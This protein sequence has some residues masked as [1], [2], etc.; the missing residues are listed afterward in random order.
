MTQSAI[1]STESRPIELAGHGLTT[2]GN[3][4]ALF[5][6][7]WSHLRGS[8]PARQT[9]IKNDKTEKKNNYRDRCISLKKRL[10]K[11]LT[12][13][14]IYQKLIS[15]KFAKYYNKSREAFPGHLERLPRKYSPEWE[16]NFQQSLDEFSQLDL[17]PVSDLL[18][19]CGF[20][21]ERWE[22][23]NKSGIFE[24]TQVID[25]HI[26]DTCGSSGTDGA[27]R[28]NNGPL[29]TGEE[30]PIFAKNPD[31]A[32]EFARR[33]DSRTGRFIPTDEEIEASKMY[34]LINHK[35]SALEKALKEAKA[36][37]TKLRAAERQA[38]NQMKQY[39]TEIEHA[40]RNG[41]NGRYKK[42]EA[43]ASEEVRDESRLTAD[44]D[45]V[46]ENE[47][48][49][50][51]VQAQERTIDGFRG[52][53]EE[54]ETEMSA[55]RDRLLQSIKRI[56]AGA[57]DGLEIIAME[58][59]D[60]MNADQLLQYA[61]GAARDLEVQKKT[62]HEGLQGIDVVKDSYESVQQLYESQQDEL[63]EQIAR[64]SSELE[65]SQH[66]MNSDSKSAGVIASQR[67]QLELLSKRIRELNSTNEKLDGTIK[68]LQRAH[69]AALK[70]TKV[71]KAYIR[72]FETLRDTL[73]IYIRER[74]DRQ[75][76]MGSLRALSSDGF[77]IP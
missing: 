24:L 56:G 31:L 43:E 21:T 58:K 61:Q 1:H 23:L 12:K 37:N 66:A 3:F 45:L 28:S 35:N 36:E 63:Q 52:R 33:C 55:V 53:Q 42:E 41:I 62:L 75:F 34:R 73:V 13:N 54:L 10:D 65:I 49:K 4:M 48:L 9:E 57:S 38:L 64:M 27:K 67:Q 7:Q 50:K 16:L 2:S 22:Q 74:Y 29:L 70:E 44:S 26:E 25:T 69:A 5:Q 17:N 68:K 40:R 39:E 20:G 8:A 47:V 14:E 60:Q 6:R 15:E 77:S 59:L 11:S 72:E 76:T 30:D 19:I 32:K 71:L 51:K 46:R 18:E